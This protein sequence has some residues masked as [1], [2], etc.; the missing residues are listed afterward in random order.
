MQY[1][2]LFPI[3]ELIYNF[4]Q[5][6]I[7]FCKWGSFFADVLFKLLEIMFNLSKWIFGN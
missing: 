1:Y 5:I 7:I 3:F 4:F 2:F 6:F